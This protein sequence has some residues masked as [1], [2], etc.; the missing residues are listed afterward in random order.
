MHRVGEARLR[1]GEGGAGSL[2]WLA[3]CLGPSVRTSAPGVASSVFGPETSSRGPGPAA[4]FTHLT[5]HWVSE[6]WVRLAPQPAWCPLGPAL[7][8]QQPLPCTGRRESARQAPQP[9]PSLLSPP[10]GHGHQMAGQDQKPGDRKWMSW[11]R[12]AEWG[13]SCRESQPREAGDGQPPPAVPQGCTLLGFGVPGGGESEASGLWGIRVF[14]H[15]EGPSLPS[16]AFHLQRDPDTMAP[17]HTLGSS[18]AR[19]GAAA[20]DRGASSGHRWEG[21]LA[22]GG[23]WLRTNPEGQ[24][25][26]DTS[27][28]P[29]WPPRPCPRHSLGDNACLSST[30]LASLCLLRKVQDA[31]R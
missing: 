9:G 4:S 27:A 20:G 11:L 25:D 16:A 17:V 1:A 18:W 23:T 5:L 26:P 13:R 14:R 10:G 2:P 29:A 6:A 8:R 3:A 24:R 31:R 21:P 12:Q 7:L 30:P 28:S 22:P 19:L 15:R